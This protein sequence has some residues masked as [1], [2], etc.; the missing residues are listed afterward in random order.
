M[1]QPREIPSATTSER[2]EI[3]KMKLDDV[4]TTDD[5][6]LLI[7]DF[8]RRYMDNNR[9]DVIEW[10]DE[11]KDLTQDVVNEAEAYMIE[12]NLSLIHI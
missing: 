5:D 11:L 1:S 8:F 4:D 12:K 2:I 3:L 6:K 7:L 10:L 9:M